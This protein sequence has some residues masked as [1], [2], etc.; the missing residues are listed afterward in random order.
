MARKL[1]IEI[2]NINAIVRDGDTLVEQDD[3]L[4]DGMSLEVYSM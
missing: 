1:R 4:V 3:D 2:H